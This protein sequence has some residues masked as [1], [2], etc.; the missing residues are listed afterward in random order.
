MHFNKMQLYF[1]ENQAD[2]R[3]FFLYCAL[4][5]CLAKPILI[6]QSYIINKNSLDTPFIIAPS[7]SQKTVGVK[8]TECSGPLGY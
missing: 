2:F 6:K 3:L 7:K 8:F 5:I 4:I 1:K